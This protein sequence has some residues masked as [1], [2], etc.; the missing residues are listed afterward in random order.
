M[1]RQPMQKDVIKKV[2]KKKIH[3]FIQKTLSYM[4][5]NIYS[6]MNITLPDFGNKKILKVNIMK[7]IKSSIQGEFSLDLHNKQ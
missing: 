6:I 1:S 4:P 7:I 5:S 2:K 3:L